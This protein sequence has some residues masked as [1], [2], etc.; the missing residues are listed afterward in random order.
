MQK[1]QY[2]QNMSDSG[3]SSSLSSTLQ[4]FL[5]LFYITYVSKTLGFTGTF[6]V[7]KATVLAIEG[8]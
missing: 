8:K 2:I 5:N 7:V 4:H 1:F 6:K 3:P